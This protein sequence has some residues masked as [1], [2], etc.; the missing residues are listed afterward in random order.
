MISGQII[1]NEQL[2]TEGFWTFES[3]KPNGRVVLRSPV[4]HCELNLIEIV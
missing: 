4:V 1:L 3:A 2:Q